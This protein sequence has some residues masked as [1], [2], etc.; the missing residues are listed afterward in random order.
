MVENM[1]DFGLQDGSAPGVPS[2]RMVAAASAA[3]LLI[4]PQFQNAELGSATAFGAD[5]D[6]KPYLITNW[7]VI[8]GRHPLTGKEIHPQCALPDELLIFHHQRDQPLGHWI[9]VKESIFED[10]RPR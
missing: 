8:T 10:E 9:P 2:I 7:H 4:V 3:S 1:T 5:C 6:G